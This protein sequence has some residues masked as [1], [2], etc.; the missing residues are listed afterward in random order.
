MVTQKKHGNS[1]SLKDTQK[2]MEFKG[3]KNDSLFFWG[4]GRREKATALDL[5]RHEIFKLE[6]EYKVN[7]LE[8]L[9]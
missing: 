8:R 9:E 2:T 6:M 1:F 4:G 7:G 5:L 3:G